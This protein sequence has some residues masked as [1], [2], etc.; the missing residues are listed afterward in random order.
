MQH[1]LFDCIVAREIWGVIAESPNILPHVS[2]TFDL[3]S[4]R[5]KKHCEALITATSATLWSLW[6]LRNNFVFQG[7]GWRSKYA[8]CFGSAGGNDQAVEDLMFRG[9]P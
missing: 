9:H 1:L 8:L 4:G 3:P 7:R 6:L 2:F 5:K